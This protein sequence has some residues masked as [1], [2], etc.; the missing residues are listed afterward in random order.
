[1]LRALRCA[2]PVRTL[3]ESYDSRKPVIRADTQQQKSLREALLRQDVKSRRNYNGAKQN[4]LRA[5]WE[6]DFFIAFI[7]PQHRGAVFPRDSPF[8]SLL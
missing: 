5:L 2:L 4:L 8:I 6:I 1:M 7:L 3:F